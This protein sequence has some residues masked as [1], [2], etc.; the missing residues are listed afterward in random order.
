MAA[1]TEYAATYQ[2]LAASCDRD[3]YDVF[4]LV[5]FSELQVFLVIIASTCRN[6]AAPAKPINRSAVDQ[7]PIT[8]CWVAGRLRACCN[9]LGR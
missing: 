8:S 7:G 6:H 2:R 3:I 4:L 1:P 9:T 5:E